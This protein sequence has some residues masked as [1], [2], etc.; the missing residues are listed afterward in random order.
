MLTITVERALELL[1]IPKPGRGKRTPLREVGPHPDDGEQ[2]AIFAGPYGQYIKHGKL[3]CSLPEG[4]APEDVTIEEA[5]ALLVAKAE[6]KGMGKVAKTTTKKTTRKP[7]AKAT[8]KTTAGTKT[9]AT[10]SKASR[11]TRPRRA[12]NPS[13][14]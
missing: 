11:A 1:A 5:V 13:A 2:V 6:A 14:P 12:A 4:K 7:A 9:V 3:N 10:T 8:K